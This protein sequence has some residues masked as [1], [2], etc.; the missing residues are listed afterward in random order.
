MVHAFFIII[1]KK[2]FH[3]MILITFIFERKKNQIKKCKHF[4]W[5]TFLFYHL[6][7]NSTQITFLWIHY[8]QNL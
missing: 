5:D 4:K 1:L 8:F 2:G 3:I 7:C 6:K